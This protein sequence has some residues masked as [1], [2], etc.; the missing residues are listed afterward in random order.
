MLKERLNYRC[1]LSTEYITKSLSYQQA[2]RQHAVKN[3]GKKYYT[4]VRR[5]IN[6]NDVLFWIL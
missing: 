3:V 6:K 1:N 2:I 4:G 5:I